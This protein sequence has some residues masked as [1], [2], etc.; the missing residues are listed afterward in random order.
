MS[1]ALEAWRFPVR[2]PEAEWD[3]F[4]R[5]FVDFRRLASSEG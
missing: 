5:D 1:F 3:E 4:D 2:K